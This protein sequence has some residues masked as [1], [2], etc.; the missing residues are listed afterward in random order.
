MDLN[1]EYMKNFYFLIRIILTIKININGNNYLTK[2][3]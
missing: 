2:E 1:P 3:F